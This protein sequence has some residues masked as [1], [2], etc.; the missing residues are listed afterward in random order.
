MLL[1]VG[2]RVQG[3]CR[4]LVSLDGYFGQ[5]GIYRSGMVNSKSF[6]GKDFL[7]NKGKYKLT[8]HFKHEMIGK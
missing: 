7:R 2:L 1:F 8:M 3:L 6:V 5:I 4:P